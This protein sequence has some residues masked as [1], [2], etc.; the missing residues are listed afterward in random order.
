MYDHSGLPLVHW[1]VKI[2]SVLR[3]C[4]PILSLDYIEISAEYV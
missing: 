2:D 1:L 4:T 3:V